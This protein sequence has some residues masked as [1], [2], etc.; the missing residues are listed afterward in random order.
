MIAKPVS[1]S[2]TT[3]DLR[4]ADGSMLR[5]LLPK[6]IRAMAM[7]ND[8]FTD[9]MISRTG[10][11]NWRSAATLADLPVRKRSAA[12]AVVVAAAKA[13]EVVLPDPRIARAEEHA[14]QLQRAFDDLTRSRDALRA[15]G[16][17]NQ[18]AL[19]TS[20]DALATSQDALARAHEQAKASAALAA[21]EL[22]E[23]Q[24][25]SEITAR[26]LRDAELA[27][28]QFTAELANELTAARGRC[29]RLVAEASQR[30]ELERAITALEL[31]IQ[32]LQQK[33]E[34]IQQT[35]AELRRQQ[36]D[37][38]LVAA[39]DTAVRERAAAA[40]ELSAAIEDRDELV[41]SLSHSQDALR[42]ADDLRRALEKSVAGLKLSL[43]DHASDAAHL[44]ATLT[45]SQSA[46]AALMIRAE[47]AEVV[48][49]DSQRVK[50]EAS[51]WVTR[52]TEQRDAALKARD[53][54]FADRDAA[55]SERDSTRLA[56]G[57]TQTDLVRV[58]RDLDG[59]RGEYTAACAALSEQTARSAA[60]ENAL[61][62]ARA[63]QLELVDER[64]ARDQ[65]IA[66]L[67]AD[68]TQLAGQIDE[69]TRDR[70]SVQVQVASN[71]VRT[72]GAESDRDNARAEV[73]ALHADLANARETGATISQ[74]STALERELAEER[75]R[76]VAR[77]ELIFR[78]SLRSEE[79][80]TENR[81]L[82]AASAALR[83]DCETQLR[84]AEDALAQI[85]LVQRDLA[86]AQQLAADHASQ[87]VQAQDE[88]EGLTLAEHAARASLTAASR[89]RD[90][91][92]AALATALA[93]VTSREQQVSAE[94]QLRDQ[95]E[96]SSRQLL[97]SYEKLA[98]DTG[99]RITDLEVK[100]SDSNR[101]MQMVR[102]HEEQLNTALSE[103]H[104]QSRASAQK[105]AAIEEQ[106]TAV[107]RDRDSHA[108]RAAAEAS[109]RAAAEDKIAIA[110]ERAAKA[111]RDARMTSER[112]LQA[113]MIA[114]GGS[115]Q[116][117]DADYAQSRAELEVLEQLV[118][119]SSRQLIA[120][121]GTVPGVPLLPREAAARAAADAKSAADAAAL[122]A[123]HIQS[124]V[125]AQASAA[126]VTP[127]ARVETS[128]PAP[129]SVNFRMVG[130]DS[131]DTT[132]ARPHSARPVAASNSSARAGGQRE[133]VSQPRAQSASS[134]G[135]DDSSSPS[136]SPRA[137]PPP[138]ATTATTASRQHDPSVAAIDQAW[139][140]DHSAIER[141]EPAPRATGVIA[142]TALVVACTAALSAIPEFA[143]LEMRSAF[144]RISAWTLAAPAL[145]AAAH[146]IAVRCEPILARRIV[147]LSSTMFA[148]A[149][150]STLAFAGAPWLGVLVAL[151]ASTTPW[152]MCYAAWPDAR[153][154]IGCRPLNTAAD[155]I[156]ER[157]AARAKIASTL[158]A[159]LALVALVALTT[160]QSVGGASIILSPSG[161]LL[162]ITLIALIAA[163]VTSSTRAH[164]PLAAWSAL[165]IV[166]SILAA[167]LWGEEFSI[168]VLAVAPSAWIAL[169]SIWSAVAVSSLACACSS[170]RLA[171]AVQNLVDDDA[172]ALVAHERFHAAWVMALTA[173]VP[174]VPALV[175]SQLVRGRS[176]RAESQLRS[177]ANFELWFAASIAVALLVT[178]ILAAQIGSSLL[179][180]LF[181]AHAA[182]CIGCAISM[183]ADRFARFPSPTPLLARP[184]GGL[185]L[186]RPLVTVQRT[187]DHSAHRPIVHPCG[188]TAWG[189]VTV[190]LGCLA[191][192]LA[193]R[194]VPITLACGPILGLALWLPSLIASR[195][196][197]QDTL[198]LCA[199]ATASPVLIAIAAFFLESRSTGDGI[200]T[201]VAIAGAGA[202][203]WALLVG[204]A[205]KGMSQLAGLVRAS[206]HPQLDEVGELVA[207]IDHPCARTRREQVMRN[208]VIG[209][210][211]SAAACAL[212]MVLAPPTKQLAPQVLV[213][214]VLSL[215]LST[216]AWLSANLCSRARLVNSAALF[217]GMLAVSSFFGALPFFFRTAEVGALAALSE[218][219]LALITA[220]VAILAAGVLNTMREPAALRAQR[221][222][223]PTTRSRSV[224]PTTRANSPRKAS[225]R[226]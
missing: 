212:M 103:A 19:A 14:E 9:D 51:A 88:L 158:T 202:G 167:S 38:K 121:G 23:L 187:T 87:L 181:T 131:D 15:E 136:D 168:G 139:I 108:K 35:N 146:A 99:R 207:P 217:T 80:E 86:S 164:A 84:R 150:L 126:A 151:G 6:Q 223:S 132:L 179:V 170:D 5:A 93:A 140:D 109:A 198:L 113:A 58:R 172:P 122:I 189:A 213:C 101:D 195:C 59:L 28:T 42:V 20:Q 30:D 145:I 44:R 216:T 138:T 185:D 219:P 29:E 226:V 177:L 97:A 141:V 69:L 182:I 210:C 128:R 209:T 10:D 53:T 194:S 215:A 211:G 78:E 125:S 75:S 201:L 73:A 50:S 64:D 70:D 134:S 119:E 186:P 96:A 41:A 91:V 77:D 143:Q 68:S 74:R 118:S 82:A 18:D 46:F 220:V 100:L 57:A 31:T 175:A 72:A 62:V 45:E 114:L 106:R 130:G 178:L 204:W 206:A 85:T 11:G 49:Q 95:A 165:A 199:I 124:T 111:E 104:A 12:A 135:D 188:T 116:R 222:P 157:F 89:E 221:V 127:P 162:S 115:K 60:L 174:V 176:R 67:R 190:S 33:N 76:I 171:V 48:A 200:P 65:M 166:I 40:Q 153:Q 3:Y 208:V 4:R 218:Q 52:T 183:G 7:A 129:H 71:A 24:R 34:S 94:R 193:T 137:H 117:L 8:L 17:L 43:S 184:D 21:Q 147:I 123:A 92:A 149:P 22:V 155:R 225:T 161:A 37:P 160:M 63:D 154:L 144:L 81:K 56:V 32:S 98:D 156:V 205:F 39:L 1:T 152:L 107:T 159:V 26:E 79:R 90:E 61:S 110:N 148:L 192:A 197:H 13:P 169:G 102:M 142:V 120:A 224:T 2:V 196:R 214:G 112:S 191:L 25:A 36:P 16:E 54:A 47:S 83:A 203:V 180:G 173:L 133:R 163:S 66:T 105:I 27:H 55:L